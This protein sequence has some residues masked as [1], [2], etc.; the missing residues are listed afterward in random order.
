M[1]AGSSLARLQLY[2]QRI[3]TT[4]SLR[5]SLRAPLM[6][7]NLTFHFLVFL[8]DGPRRSLS[9]F[10]SCATYLSIQFA[11]HRLKWTEKWHRLWVYV[12]T[13][14]CVRSQ[15][16]KN[17]P[18][19][20]YTL[21]HTDANKVSRF[22]NT[23][24]LHPGWCLAHIFPLHEDEDEKHPLLSA[25]CTLSFLEPFPFMFFQ[26]PHPLH[27]WWRFWRQKQ[28]STGRSFIHSFIHSFIWCSSSR[29]RP[30]GAFAPSVEDLLSLQLRN[31][32]AKGTIAKKMY[33]FE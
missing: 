24:I 33:S 19:E 16:D 6:V 2:T 3:I 22:S 31:S 14:V 11:T 4:H 12:C 20:K 9:P 15:M 25:K 26:P 27:W 1:H 23:F 13:T 8:S 28:A 10:T 30:K 29:R 17:K 5:F 18:G 21:T 7:P 32:F